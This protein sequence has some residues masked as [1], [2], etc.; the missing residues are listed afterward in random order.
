MSDLIVIQPQVTELTVTEQVNQVTVASVGVQGAKGDTGA[1][2]P[3]GATGATGATGQ[4]SL[5]ISSGYYIATPYASY[6]NITATLSRTNYVPI[7]ITKTTSI[8]RIAV[9]TAGTFVGTAVVRLGI[10]ANDASTGQ[11]NTLILDAGTISCTASNTVYQITISQ[12]LDAGFYWLA[13]NTQTAAT[14]NNFIGN[15][16]SQG[17]YNVYMPY[18]PTP[19]SNYQTG[20]REE[21]ITGAFANAGTLLGLGAT[22]IAF[23]RAA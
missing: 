15:S 1:T 6:A 8:D 22:P 18:K 12:S 10:Y 11:P 21:S 7:Y 2:G 17:A 3:T 19:T 5:P 23:L 13:I 20:W 4:S 14:T 9:T 16:A